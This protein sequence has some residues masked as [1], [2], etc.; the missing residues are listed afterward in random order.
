MIGTRSPTFQPNCFAIASPT[1]RLRIDRELREEV[2]LV[3]VVAAEPLPLARALHAGHRI[4]LALVRERQVHP[5]AHRRLDPEP[6]LVRRRDAG[7][8]RGHERAQEAE[9]EDRDRER[10]DR[11]QRAHLVAQQASPDELVHGGIE[12]APGAVT[13]PPGPPT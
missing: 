11:E 10:P 8:E 4:D 7:L 5:E 2:A 6:L 13:Y 9:Q 3:L 1:K 12:G